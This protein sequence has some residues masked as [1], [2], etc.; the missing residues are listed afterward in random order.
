[1]EPEW[2]RVRIQSRRS[3]IRWDAVVARGTRTIRE[4]PTVTPKLFEARR[5]TWQGVRPIIDAA[6]LARADPKLF[7]AAAVLLAERSAIMAW[8]H[9]PAWRHRIPSALRRLNQAQREQGDP[10]RQHERPSITPRGE[11]SLLHMTDWRPTQATRRGRPS[12]AVILSV[13][14]ELAGHLLGVRPRVD[15]PYRLLFQLYQAIWPPLFGTAS[16]RQLQLLVQKH[17]T[18]R[19]RRPLR[20]LL[21][22]LQAR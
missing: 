16:S 13:F 21:K 7:R 20:A 9:A 17:R 10:K 4:P 12:D 8:R 18:R 14:S 11:F 1:M 3:R 6:R 2:G 5:L 15:S 22:R 19:P